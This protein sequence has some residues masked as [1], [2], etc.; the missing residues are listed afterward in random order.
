VSFSFMP[1]CGNLPSLGKCCKLKPDMRRAYLLP[2][3]PDRC[4]RKHYARIKQEFPSLPGFLLDLYPRA[5]FLI[6]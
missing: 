3:S 2:H 6:I 5:L 4:L 1:D